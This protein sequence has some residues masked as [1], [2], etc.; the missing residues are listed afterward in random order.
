[1]SALI[2]EAVVQGIIAGKDSRTIRVV[3]ASEC[4]DATQCS[5]GCG[6]CG[7]KKKVI[8]ITVEV[9][10]TQQFE[11]GTPVTIR[12]YTINEFVGALVVFGIPLFLACS[13]LLSWYIFSP[14]SAESARAMVSAAVA[15]A[16]GFAVIRVVDQQFRR[17]FPTRIISYH[18]P[19][20]TSPPAEQDN[21]H[22][23]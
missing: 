1:M 6:A 15:F 20:G 14:E 9:D 7:G 3:P 13:V 23:G 21:P 4:G 10:S 5:V 18:I 8:K 12:H 19:S 17:R 11:T 22:D 2:N 16:A